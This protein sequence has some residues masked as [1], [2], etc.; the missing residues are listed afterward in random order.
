MTCFL[1][2]SY[3]QRRCSVVKM[4]S[5][6]TVLPD[7]CIN[8]I[9]DYLNIIDR[10]SLKNTCLQFNHA[11]NHRKTITVETRK[12]DVKL[13]KRM[14]RGIKFGGGRQI[15]L[16]RNMI[17]KN[18]LFYRD[19][20]NI[21]RRSD[22]GI[23]SSHHLFFIRVFD[24]ENFRH[25][26]DIRS[27]SQD[28]HTG[29][30]EIRHH[31]PDYFSYN[32]DHGMYKLMD[33]HTR[34]IKASIPIMDTENH[35]IVET[36]SPKGFIYYFRKPF[37]TIECD[38]Y[39]FVVNKDGQERVIPEIRIKSNK[40]LRRHYFRHNE[41]PFL[42]AGDYFVLL[43]TEKIGNVDS[44]DV[45]G[46]VFNIGQNPFNPEFVSEFK[47][48]F[49]FAS[50]YMDFEE[51][52]FRPMP[53]KMNLKRHPTN[54]TLIEVC[55][56]RKDMRE[57]SLSHNV[58]IFDLKMG[59]H[60]VGRYST[61]YRYNTGNDDFH[62]MSRPNSSCLK[63]ADDVFFQNERVMTV[64]QQ[65]RGFDLKHGIFCYNSSCDDLDSFMNPSSVLMTIKI[66]SD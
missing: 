36:V 7:L 42:I 32:V 31:Y 58:E 19:N 45:Y 50:S 11:L 14:N 3:F 13:L 34:E 35:D 53:F 44:L 40:V 22:D 12:I 49:K 27:K 16:T 47:T 1:L 60:N 29:I 48:G 17:Y 63:P 20:V 9:A 24:L 46:K 65:V 54:S 25:Q 26:Y 5:S 38:E 56:Y 61:T 6:L 43:Y 66:D 39:E 28:Y 21:I 64:K 52:V 2:P 23:S 62:I 30:S 10:K 37:G 55:Q 33:R 51:G 41:G 59:G 18:Q 15:P 4:S 57:D 8:R